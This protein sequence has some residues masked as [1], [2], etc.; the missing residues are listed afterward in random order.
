MNNFFK[1]C[2]CKIAFDT[3]FFFFKVLMG[4]NVGYF[5]QNQS[6]VTIQERQTAGVLFA[7]LLICDTKGD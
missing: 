7:R 2:K 5:T 1:F 4:P 6:Y 3:Y